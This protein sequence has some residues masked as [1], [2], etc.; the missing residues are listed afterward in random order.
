MSDV[1]L[2][3]DQ[4]LYYLIQRRCRK[5][6]VFNVRPTRE[7]L[8]RTNVTVGTAFHWVVSSSSSSR[9]YHHPRAMGDA[10][11]VGD[12]V[13]LILAAE[14]TCYRCS[15][16]RWSDTDVNY[17]WRTVNGRYQEL[18]LTASHI[19]S[20]S[21]NSLSVRHIFLFIQVDKKLSC[22]REAARHSVSL[23]SL[24]SHSRSLKVV[25]NYT[26]E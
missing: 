19:S 11:D 7:T 10:S 25:R 24:L 9:R 23:E 20:A 5:M 16:C 8:R 2:G 15:S 12:T 26:V 3:I 22:R 4:Y 18:L 13:Q 21:S 6:L 1:Q 17:S 14:S